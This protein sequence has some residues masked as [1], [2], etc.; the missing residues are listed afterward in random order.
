MKIRFKECTS[1]VMYSRPGMV[2][3]VPDTL[4]RHL[5]SL[6]QAEAIEEAVAAA[7]ETAALRPR[8][9]KRKAAE[10]ASLV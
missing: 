10:Q 4:A 9:G 7:P 6:G 3:E 1:A 2:R 5:I 8:R